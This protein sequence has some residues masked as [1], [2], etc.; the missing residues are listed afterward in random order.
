MKLFIYRQTAL[1]TKETFVLA[2]AAV[3]SMLLSFLDY[4][5]NALL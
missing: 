5:S 4:F 2:S 3:T 1:F